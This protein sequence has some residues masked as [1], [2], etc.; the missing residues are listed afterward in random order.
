MPTIKEWEEDEVRRSA[1]DAAGRTPDLKANPANIQ[2]Y[3]NP[4]ATTA[5]PLEYAFRLVG[6]LRGKRVLD[7]GCGAG[8]NTILL[9]AKGAD[10]IGM[11]ISPDL[12]ELAKERLRVNGYPGT[13][14]VESCHG[15]KFPDESF[16]VI[17][18]AAILHHLDLR[19]ARA[20]VLRLLKRGGLAVFEE[21]TRDSRVLRILRKLVP[22]KSPLASANER[23]LTTPELQSF[24]AGFEVVEWRKFMLPHVLAIWA[25]FPSKLHQAFLLDRWLLKKMP[26]LHPWTGDVVIA[27][28]KI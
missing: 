21:P 9:A 23:P 6:N 3:Q 13:A 26:W 20:E 15:T 7:F 14:V 19:L 12:V 24:A 16:D 1:I 10:V 4:P 18:G 2:R 8:E 5:Y 25:V 28:R 17:F 27:I 11:D 22:Y